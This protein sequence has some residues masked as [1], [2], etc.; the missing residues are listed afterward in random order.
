[1]IRIATIAALAAFA[2]A[3]AFAGDSI[4]V[5]LTGKSP[6]QVRT[7]VTVA[8]RKLCAREIVGATFPNEEMHA[9]LRHTV[10]ATLAQ[11]QDP[12]IRLAQQ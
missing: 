10:K 5:S 2:A 4:R 9:C 6:D 3:P 8:A 1:M 7:E 11:A 12:A